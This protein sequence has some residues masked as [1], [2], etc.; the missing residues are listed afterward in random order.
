MKLRICMAILA[1]SGFSAW[2]LDEG[3]EF[4]FERDPA[5]IPVSTKRT[6]PGG[7]DEEDLTVQTQLPEAT[8]KT[9]AR[10]I[11]K[12]VYKSVYNQELKDERQD[13]VE[14]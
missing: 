12:E 2:A 13:A 8:L 11:Q 7:A 9:D 3:A 10:G 14:E 6:Y 1:L 5:S 4:E